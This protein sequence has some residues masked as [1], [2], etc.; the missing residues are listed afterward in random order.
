MNGMRLIDADN[1]SFAATGL[2]ID[3]KDYLSR[4]DISDCVKDEDANPTIDPVHA[5]GGCYCYEC[6]MRQGLET[7]K[8]VLCGYHNCAM[9]KDDFCSF[10]K[11][12]DN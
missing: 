10:G 5:A 1:F 2:V 11:K 8:T 6:R 4:E 12:S 7:E 3:G 9:R